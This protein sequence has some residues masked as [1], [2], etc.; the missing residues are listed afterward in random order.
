[1]I[2]VLL[3]FPMI[4]GISL[5]IISGLIN[6]SP[7]L[8]RKMTF[9]GVLAFGLVA[10]GVAAVMLVEVVRVAFP[11]TYRWSDRPHF[12]A[13]GIVWA[14]FFAGGALLLRPARARLTW[15]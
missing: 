6:V 12:A 5:A 8:L 7:E 11:R 15:P 13:V 14:V 10:H 2:V 4:A 3:L 9:P 1:L